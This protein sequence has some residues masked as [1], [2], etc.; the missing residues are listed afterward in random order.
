MPDTPK[1]PEKDW[2]DFYSEATVLELWTELRRRYDPL[3]EDVAQE[4]LA[5]VLELCPLDPMSYGR[6]IA[7]KVALELMLPHVER[8]P[9]GTDKRV[10]REIPLGLPADYAAHVGARRVDMVVVREEVRVRRQEALAHVNDT[11]RMAEC[12]PDKEAVGY[13]KCWLCYSRDRRRVK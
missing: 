12:H 9:D 5:R 3:N 4:V 7:P 6:T 1:P 2:R 11:P 10:R 13:G 8:Q